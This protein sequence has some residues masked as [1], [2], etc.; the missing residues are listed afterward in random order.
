[1]RCLS[2]AFSNI[3]LSNIRNKEYV[4]LNKKNLNLLIIYKLFELGYIRGFNFDPFYNFKVIIFLKY[5]NNYPVISNI[6]FIGNTT[7]QFSFKILEIK[8]NFLLKKSFSL[9][10][11]N[12]G[13]FS[14]I[15]CITNN[16]GGFLLISF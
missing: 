12:K 8:K 3:K 11:T 14:A 1:M 2:K 10:T 13:I 15:D 6:K 16:T 4:L 9:F 7:Q 5:Y